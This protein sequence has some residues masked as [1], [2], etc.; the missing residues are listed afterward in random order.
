[1]IGLNIRFDVFA[2]NKY[3]NMW[4]RIFIIVKTNDII[5]LKNYKLQKPIHEK[6]VK[7]II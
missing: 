7:I 6:S 1:M 2:A 4:V 3:D 5:F